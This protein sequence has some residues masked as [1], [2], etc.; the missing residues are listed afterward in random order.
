MHAGHNEVSHSTQN[1][2]RHTT[3]PRR[4]STLSIDIISGAFV[5][6]PLSF[7]LPVP[8]VFPPLHYFFLGESLMLGYYAYPHPCIHFCI[9]ECFVVVPLHT[10]HP[11]PPSSFFVLLF[12]IIAL[13]YTLF[14]T[15]VGGISRHS[16]ILPEDVIPW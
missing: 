16:A 2:S 4:Q 13:F 11:S 10:G 6:L 12:V 14:Y 8:S 3:E 1:S 5:H 15:V 9:F 7:A